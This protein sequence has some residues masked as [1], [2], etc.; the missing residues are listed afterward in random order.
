MPVELE[1]PQIAL[2][3]AGEPKDPVFSQIRN[4]IYQVSGIYQA[5]GRLYLLADACGRRMKKIEVKTPR[6]Y[7]DLL[8]MKASREA[9]LR[10]LLNEVTIG[11]TC[12]FRSSPQVEALTKVILPELVKDKTRQIIKRLRIWSA[13][14]STGAEPHTLAILAL[15]AMSGLLQG[16]KVEILATD[17]NDRS[18]ETAKLGIYGEY[19]LR[20]TSALIKRKYFQAT[21][22]PKKLQVRDEVKKL[23]AF[24]RLNLHDDAKMT[25]MRGIDLLC[26]CNVLIYFDA[27]SKSRVITHFFNDLT[28]GGYFLL[29]TSESLFQINNQF[30]LVH[31]PGTIAYWKAPAGAPIP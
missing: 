14:C 26:C 24:S 30:R 27:A 9:E 28:P 3:A 19:A 11:E 17:L 2:D 22:D 8:T 18:I 21:D 12:L 16:W 31:F 13:G 6:A 1:R 15:E 25:F 29:G 7:F 5:D 23:I 20:N 4:M 10:E